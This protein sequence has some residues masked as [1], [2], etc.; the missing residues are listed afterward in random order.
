MPRG[1]TIPRMDGTRDGSLFSPTDWRRRLQLVTDAAR[2]LS[3]R[4]TAADILNACQTRRRDWL[5]VDGIL[6]V[7]RRGLEPPG[8]RITVGDP[9]LTLMRS[10]S[11]AAEGPIR[12]GGILGELVHAGH[13]TTIQELAIDPRDPAFDHLRDM[14]SLAAVPH[15]DD[16]QTA[17]MVIYLRRAPHAFPPEHLPELVLLVNLFGRALRESAVVQ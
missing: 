9:W 5:P 17:E 14:G 4:D 1:D 6:T 8:F 7:S 16:G 11:A 3:R 15:F 12:E 10:S 2:D 13:A